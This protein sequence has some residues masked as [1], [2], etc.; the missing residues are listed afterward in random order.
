[1]NRSPRRRGLR[2]SLSLGVLAL[3][4]VW[5]A[6]WAQQVRRDGFEGQETAWQKGTADAAYREI[7][8]AV[9]AETAHSGQTSEH[10]RFNAEQGSFVYYF[11]PVGRAPVSDELTVSLWL[12]SNRP[13]V[14]LLGRLVLPHERSTQSFEDRMV[15]VLRGDQ[16]QNVGR[17]QRL[18]LRRP[19]KLAKE[20]QQLVRAELQRDVDFTDAYIDRVM[21][22]VYGGPGLT[23]V[24]IDDLEVGPVLESG[25]PFE[26]T[27]RPTGRDERSPSRLPAR[28]SL[29]ELKQDRLTVNGR[30]FLMRGIRHTGT[31]L[32]V[33]REA[34]FNTVWF[35]P[36]AAPETIAEAV[37]LGLW[38]V[39]SVRTAG[40]QMA[41]AELREAVTR[42]PASDAVLFWDL[43]GG[44]VEEQK[45]EVLG[46]ADVVHAAD[47]QRPVGADIW[48]GFRPYSRSLDLV[49]IHRWPLMTTLELSAYHEWLDQRRLLARPGSFTWTWVQTHL[50]DWFTNLVYGQGAASP[51]TEPIGPQ[52]EQIRLLTYT[53]VAAGCRGLGFWSDEFLAD[54]H[55]G[56]DR[57]LELGLLN[58]ELQMLEPMLSSALPPRWVATSVPDVKAAV[59]RTEQGT[60]VL[61]MWVGKGAQFVPG[62]AAAAKL[63]V[64]VP[65]VPVGTQAWEISPADVHSLPSERVPGGTRVVIDEM[66]MT[67]TVLFTVDNNPTGV[68]VRLQD[69]A[70]RTRKLAA[71][72][73]HGLAELELQKVSKIEAELEALGQSPPDARSLLDDART[74]IRRSVE[75]WNAGDYAQSYAEA[76][77][78]LRPLRILMRAQWEQAVRG[79]DSPV[80]SPYAVSFYTLPR[81][82]R[83]VNRLR[84]AG[85]GANVLADGSFEAPGDGSQGWWQKLETKLDPVEFSVKRVAERPKDG[86]QCLCLEVK[87]QNPQLPPRALERT[88]LAVQSAP[89]HLPPGTPV[90]ISGW[91][92]IPESIKASVDGALIYDSAGGEPLGVRLTDAPKWQRVTLYRI[93]PAS[94]NVSVTLALTGLGKAY[95]D[96]VRIEPLTPSAPGVAAAR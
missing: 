18:E 50:P 46:A 92:R 40:R 85:A 82:W 72:W 71:Q 61:P 49:G 77:R 5:A 68:V 39:P 24:W 15:T 42:F 13:G 31:P 16:Y 87:A 54:N 52:P 67:G 90:M 4:G 84:G 91:V 57:L 95:F 25:G 63:A 30:P 79:L 74:R 93:V 47:P 81:H 3:A 56:R 2:A 43:G 89:S 62:Q 64:V 55:Q 9:T 45:V 8:H 27:S 60:L 12:K 86:K 6:V 83:F 59:I 32:R 20:Q 36:A 37:N 44:V 10:V 34:G 26:T 21:L 66:G 69:Q 94:G 19:D 1:M 80:S 23:D 75:H 88:F 70:R 11:Y 48:D 7:L 14:Q 35:E 76:D 28:T 78:A 51:F 53:A 96:D 29:V 73:S 17:W 33:L 58:L 41:A 38:V 65:D 22:N